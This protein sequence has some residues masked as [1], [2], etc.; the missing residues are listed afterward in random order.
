MNCM[1]NLITVNSIGY[2]KVRDVDGIYFTIGKRRN[3]ERSIQIN[4]SNYIITI[5]LSQ[6]YY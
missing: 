4:K 5:L 1:K 6:L 2:H 3:K